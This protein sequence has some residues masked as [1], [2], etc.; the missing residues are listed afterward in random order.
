MLV[1]VL[2]KAGCGLECLG[3]HTM[4]HDNPLADSNIR[5][6]SCVIR[7]QHLNTMAL[8]ISGGKLNFQAVLIITL[9]VSERS[10]SRPGRSNQKDSISSTHWIADYDDQKN[11]L[12]AENRISDV[13]PTH[14]Y[15]PK[16]CLTLHNMDIN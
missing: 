1:L 3:V 5:S 10:A 15:L 2:Y 13:K 11:S 14:I 4:P 6:E 12:S 8:A 16:F 9:L 7:V